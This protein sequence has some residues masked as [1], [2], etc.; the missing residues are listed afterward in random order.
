MFWYVIC[1]F[2]ELVNGNSWKWKY[3]WRELILILLQPEIYWKQCSYKQALLY[4][5][6]GSFAFYCK[7]IAPFCLVIILICLFMSVCTSGNGSIVLLWCFIKLLCQIITLWT[8]LRPDFFLRSHRSGLTLFRTTIGP[9]SL[10][11]RTE[12]FSSF[13]TTEC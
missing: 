11:D 10:P 13:C 9:A 2:M 4:V 5:P 8:S 3:S 1:L 12:S 7:K 6:L